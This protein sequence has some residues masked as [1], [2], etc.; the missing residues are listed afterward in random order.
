MALLPLMEVVLFGA[1]WRSQKHPYIFVGVAL[2]ALYPIMYACVAPIL[3]AVGISGGRPPLPAITAMDLRFLKAFAL[4]VASSVTF[5]WAL[6]Y[7][8]NKV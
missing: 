6:R 4:F 7:A 5:L 1:I 2:V 8:L 3:T